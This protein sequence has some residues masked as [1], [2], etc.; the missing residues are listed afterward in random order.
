MTVEKL[1]DKTIGRQKFCRETGYSEQNVHRAIQEG[2]MPS[3]WFINVRS[4]CEAEGVNVP[5][6]LFRWSSKRRKP[7]A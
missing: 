4:L 5:E 6:S 1:I 7:A 3:G 2:I